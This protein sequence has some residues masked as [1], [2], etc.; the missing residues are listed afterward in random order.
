MGLKNDLDQVLDLVDDFDW[1][2]N[3]QCFEFNECDQLLPFVA[4]GKAVFGVEYVLNPTTF[5][6]Q[7]NGMNFYWL[8]KNIALDA[9]RI[10][11]R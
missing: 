8:K 6:P 1:T 9:G 4:A 2:L 5:C 7:A 11:C 3:E 10:S